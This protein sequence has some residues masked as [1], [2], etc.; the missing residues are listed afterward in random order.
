MNDDPDYDE[1]PELRFIRHALRLLDIPFEESDW[2][3]GKTWRKERITITWGLRSITD[4]PSILHPALPTTITLPREME[5]RLAAYMAAIS[6]ATEL[7]FRDRV[8]LTAIV[9]FK[10]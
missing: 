2:L 8:L 6:Q 4:P 7:S 3:H 10:P 5:E 9:S 1:V